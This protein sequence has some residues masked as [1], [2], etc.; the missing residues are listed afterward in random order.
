[1]A[2][3]IVSE[4]FQPFVDDP[5]TAGIVTDFDGTLAPIVADPPT[6]RPL[7]AVPQLLADLADRYALVAV[8][9]GRPASFLV[10]RLGGD[11]LPAN[12]AL[13]G[14]YGL[15]RVARRAGGPPFVAVHA[16]AQPWISA[17][18]EAAAGAEAS[19]PPG[20][21][22]ERKGL[23]VTIH[24]RT[25]PEHADWAAG[26]TRDW[27]AVTGL[28]VH[29][30]R[31]SWELR[32]P[33]RV[34]KGT[35][36][37]ELVEGLATA[38]FAGDDVGDLPAFDALDRLEASGGHVVRVAVRSPEAPAELLARGDLVADGPEGVAALFRSLL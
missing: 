7:P 4:L 38:L 25:A 34:D 23:S 5:T 14:L 28:A 24:V 17:I 18:E 11:G 16:E 9:S 33:V 30:G 20:V 8:V 6:A 19:A 3:E 26:W 21:Y 1:M 22:V 29:P 15:E 10:D 27:A 36:V 13:S 32:P 2:A 31:L 12:L 37:D 35:V